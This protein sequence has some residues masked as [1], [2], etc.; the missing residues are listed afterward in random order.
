VDYRVS[1]QERA[2]FKRCR[3][4]WD[5]G[6]AH[7]QNLQAVDPPPVDLNQAVRDALA[8][9]YYPGMWDWD[10]HIVLPLVRKAF[11]RTMAATAPSPQRTADVDLGTDLLE[12]YFA[13]A[14]SVDDFGPLKIETDVEAL[15]PDIR[16][17]DSGLLTE[18]GRRVLYTERIALLAVDAA[19]EYWVV[20]H[21][22]VPEWQDVESM[23]LDEALV[24][25]C[26]AWEETYLGMEIA[27]TIHNEILRAAPET[28]SP[29]PT[30]TRT[31]R[32]GRG[33]HDQN[34]PSGGGRSTP[35][36]QRPE[37]LGSRLPSG[38]RV[39]QE[40]AGILRRTRIR[41]SRAEIETT[42]LQIGAEVL[43]MLDRDLRLYPTPAAEHCPQCVF[44]APCLTMIEGADPT[45]DLASRFREGPAVATYEPRLGAGGGGGRI[46]AMPPPPA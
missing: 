27:G 22:V 39:E 46:I 24:A 37:R 41:R 9:Y 40:T 38:G 5:F 17:P 30:E 1:A 11:M 42:R 23:Q 13:W 2:A 33:G 35:Q 16:A 4:Q 34:E 28:L 12:R 44:V 6:S 36:L 20:T 15:V 45:L 32:P 10:S 31:G 8:V 19:D 43:E 25:A 3:R 26:W 14:P 29:V 7:R 21:Q 18:A